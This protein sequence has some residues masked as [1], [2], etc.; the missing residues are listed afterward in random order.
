MTLLSI[1]NLHVSVEG[2][3]IIKG[4]HLSL[5]K[6]KIHALM[7]PN[8]AGK[9]TLVNTLMGH[10]QYSVTQGSI[11]FN[12]ED[13]TQ[14][15]PDERA[16]RGLFLCFQY[17]KEI[18]GVT[19]TNLLRTA[20]NARRPK[21]N[22]ITIAAF[23][24]LLREKMNALKVTESFVSRYVNEGFSGGEKKKAEILQLAV[25]DPSLAIL[26]ETDSGLDID[27]LRIVAQGVNTFMSPEKCILI[28]THYKRILEYIKPD[29]LLIMVDGKV[30]MEGDG[31][32]V[33]HLEEKGYEWITKE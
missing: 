17:P 1:D 10:P 7:G 22:P 21:E 24:Q 29:K 11:V 31:S 26:D 4:L 13:I 9:S 23:Q 25:L 6:G 5:E 15:S 12:G 32:L 16:K 20:L 30:A 19:L 27:S 33:D 14:L 3:E 28:I 18:P 2:K 8:G